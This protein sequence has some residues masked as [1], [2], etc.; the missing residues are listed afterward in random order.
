MVMATG[1]VM[2]L[3]Y[4]SSTYVAKDYVEGIQVTAFGILNFFHAT[5]SNGSTTFRMCSGT[6][7]NYLDP[8]LASTND[9]FFFVL[10]LYSGLYTY[11]EN[12]NPQ[13]ALAE[14]YTVS[15]DGLTY[16]YTL[17]PDLKWSDGSSLTA[18]DFVYAWKRAVDPKTAASYS[19]CFSVFDGY[20]E[21]NLNVV[22]LDDRT[23][24]FKL[25]SPCS[26]LESLLCLPVFNP[27]C[28]SYVERFD[29]SVTP[30]A[31]C[32]D[33]NFVCNGPYTATSWNHNVSMVLE[34]NPYYYDK[35]NLSIK[36]AEIM[37][38]A[39]NSAAFIAYSAGDLDLTEKVPVDEMSVLV[40]N[41][42]K[43]LHNDPMFGVAYIAM[44]CND[45]L[46]DGLTPE[47]AACM[48]RGMSLLINRDFVCKTIGRAGIT[49]A[50]SFI[51]LGMSDGNGGVLYDQSQTN[52]YYD[53]Y[54]MSRHPEETI[55]L[56]RTYL[57]AAGYLFDENGKLSPETPLTITYTY[58]PSDTNTSVA[59]NIQQDLGVIG[60]DVQLSQ[61]EWNVLLAT[62]D[63][64]GITFG[65][66]SWIADYNNPI[67]ML[68]IFISTSSNNSTHFGKA[69][70]SN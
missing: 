33:A 26:Y 49:P 23:L 70:S 2:P 67:A 39:D 34:A 64:V 27:I 47:Q 56:A 20:E 51:P 14:S 57:K 6:E 4:D 60:I 46:Y 19:N 17:R 55:E 13:F 37:L 22:A 63:S 44:N 62:R 16:T 43:E 25:V 12:N 28:Q 7:P 52:I 38:T 18:S 32:L 31:W 42:S 58:N 65:R 30:N 40:K 1:C 45:E 41:N 8:A 50:S 5:L 9:A 11:D 66:G 69:T 36:R 59:E 53:A 29:T 10:Y 68:E 15:G 54:G 48:R 24:Q 61:M 35:E 3:Y 21:G